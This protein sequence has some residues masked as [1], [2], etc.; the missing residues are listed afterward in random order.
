MYKEVSLSQTEVT[1]V[2][3]AAVNAFTALIHSSDPPIEP[4]LLFYSLNSS[5]FSFKPFFVPPDKK[6]LSANAKANEA[7]S[8]KLWNC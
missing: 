5:L 3:D 1:S 2:R 8:Y 4:S 6:S 7:C